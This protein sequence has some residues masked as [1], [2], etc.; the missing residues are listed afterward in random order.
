LG[1]SE[2]A[3]SWDDAKIE[4]ALSTLRGEIKQ[5]PPMY[6]AKKVGGR[7][8]YE[9]ARKGQEVDRTAVSVTVREFEVRL[10]NGELLTH[11]TDG[12]CDMAI[13]VVCSAGTYVRTLAEDLGERLGVGA[14][15]F[16]LRRTRA[17]E[18]KISEAKTL[19]NLEQYVSSNGDAG[20]ALLPLR[21]A[22]SGMASTQL[23]DDVAR[24][25]SHGATVASDDRFLDGELV[26]L[27]DKAGELIAIGVYDLEHQS[28]R[29]RIV[30]V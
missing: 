27:C 20:S 7:K 26:Q 2:F 29:P 5:L 3:K 9:L 14:H 22:L 6:S 4:T 23:E 11:N 21:N 13:R 28:I 25:V 18:F 30:L 10:T 8:L 1:S 24:R 15:L 16:S 12:T 19:E 17:G